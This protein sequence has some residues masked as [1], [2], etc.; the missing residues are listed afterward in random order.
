LLP[1]RLSNSLL[2]NKPMPTGAYRRATP[3]EGSFFLFDFSFCALI[4]PGVER[5][6]IHYLAKVE[7]GVE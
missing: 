2:N 3:I 1:N 5:V 4:L 6:F 7:G